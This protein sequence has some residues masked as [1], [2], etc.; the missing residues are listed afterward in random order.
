VQAIFDD[1][2]IDCHDASKQ[3]IPNDP[4]LPLTADASYD[5]LVNHKADADCGGVRVVPGDPDASY[6]FQKISEE[7][8]C[9]G[10]RMP[11]GHE[12]IVPPPLTDEQIA[13]IRSWILAGAAR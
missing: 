1:R 13:L 10:P 11:R 7:M 6:L 3:G 9:D 4:S 12:L 5:A 8:P 2:C